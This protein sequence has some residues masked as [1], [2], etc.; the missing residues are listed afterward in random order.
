MPITDIYMVHGPLNRYNSRHHSPLPVQ[1]SPPR[2]GKLVIDS[3]VIIML[4]CAHG[5]II[6]SYLLLE[7]LQRWGIDA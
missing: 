5:G 1:P 2:Q 6:N 4:S 7:L 3:H